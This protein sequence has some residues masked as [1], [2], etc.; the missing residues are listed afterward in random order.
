MTEEQ[1][2]A[3][4]MISAFPST[5][6]Y[7]EK[8]I[9]PWCLIPPEHQGERPDSGENQAA[10]RALTLQKVRT[11]GDYSLRDCIVTGNYLFPSPSGNSRFAMIF[12]EPK[13]SPKPHDALWGFVAR[14]WRLYHPD[15]SKSESHGRKASVLLPCR[16][17]DTREEY[18]MAI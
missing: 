11:C 14:T 16:C 15:D 7:D 12:Q 1:Q 13:T 9:P 5:Y 10:G 18:V 4:V 8:M 17:R 3:A 6:S 2:N